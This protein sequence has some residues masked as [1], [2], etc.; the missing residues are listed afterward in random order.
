MDNKRAFTL[1]ELIAVMAVLA[2]IMLL[3]VPGLSS[4]KEDNNQKQFSTY[5]DMMVEYARAYPN[6][7]TKANICLKDLDINPINE[8]V[9]CKGYVKVLST[10][11]KAYIACTQNGKEVYKTEGYSLPSG[12]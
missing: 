9:S 7:K 11:L 2:L 10:S 6:Y 4:L 12:C 1:V 3:V 8:K 5:E